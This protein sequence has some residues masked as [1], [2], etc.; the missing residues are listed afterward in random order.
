MPFF[1]FWPDARLIQFSVVMFLVIITKTKPFRA[2]KMPCVPIKV[3][4]AVIL[5]PLLK[6][7]RPSEAEVG[8]SLERKW[9]WSPGGMF[10]NF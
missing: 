4:I 10:P 1:K 8:I 7:L 3:M 6:G 2:L 5:H 9:A